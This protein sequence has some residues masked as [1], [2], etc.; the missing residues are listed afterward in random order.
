MNKLSH[1]Y[2]VLLFALAT[3][4]CSL[5]AKDLTVA[6]EAMPSV[7][8]PK[9]ANAK[10]FERHAKHL[11][12]ARNG[13]VGVLFLGDSIT[14]GW[15]KKSDIWESAWGS[16]QPANFGIGGDRTQ[17]VIWRIEQGALDRVSPK[18]VVLM[19]GTNNTGS[20]SAADIAAA[21]RKIVRMIQE[22]L[23][24]TKILLLAIFPRG[25]R[26]GSDG[27]PEAWETRMEKIKAVNAQ[28]AE[29]DNGRSIR[30]LDFGDKFKDP[31]GSIPKSVM[32]DQLH[33]SPTGYQIWADS[34]GPLLAE[35]ME[36]Q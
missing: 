29:L 27:K 14:E 8:T 15:E 23:P 32:P 7:G 17:H 30:F 33:L 36:A 5:H 26:I 25:P 2:S 22:A 1:N 6:T 3:V 18:V 4:A 11:K 34:M 28:L 9:R 16:Y 10:F 12:R 20:D 13:P 19:L 35:M 24:E 31:D 21:D